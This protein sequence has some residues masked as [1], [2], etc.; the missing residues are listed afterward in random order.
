MFRTLF[1]VT[2]E[3]SRLVSQWDTTARISRTVAAFY[4]YRNRAKL[5]SQN[6]PALAKRNKQVSLWKENMFK[7]Q[8]YKRTKVSLRLGDAYLE[9]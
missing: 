9:C 8:E 2:P 6:R 7:Q 5:N 1:L 4:K 3:E